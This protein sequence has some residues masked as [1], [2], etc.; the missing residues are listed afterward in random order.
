MACSQHISR[1]GLRGFIL[2]IAVVVI[3]GAFLY[4]QG[5]LQ[6]PL[7]STTLLLSMASGEEGFAMAGE[8]PALPDSEA[9]TTGE[10]AAEVD[11]AA[12][13]AAAEDAAQ[14]TGVAMTAMQTAAGGAASSGMTLEQLTAELAAAGVDVEAV[15]AEMSA[16]GRS[17]ENLLSVVNSGR[18]TVADLAAR[19]NGETTTEAQMPPSES[20][21]SLLDLRWDE[22]GSIA[23]N[24][25]VMLAATLAVIVLGRPVGWLVSRV[26]RVPATPSASRSTL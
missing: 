1:R 13:A 21:T 17:L 14:T 5:D 24:L 23:Y 18:V 20:S 26:R 7:Q 2:L 9:G 15:S 25:W 19:L 22:L 4:A 10:S 12:V 16:G 11:S 8:R 3:S 6:S